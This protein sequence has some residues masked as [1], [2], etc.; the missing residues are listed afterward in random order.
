VDI[1]P[2]IATYHALVKLLDSGYKFSVIT[3]EHA[4][5]QDKDDSRGKSREFLFKM[6]YDL[7]V[8]NVR[9]LPDQYEFEDWWVHPDLVDMTHVEQ[10]RSTSEYIFWKKYLYGLT[11]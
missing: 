2:S 11:K 8:P 7:L 4:N 10:F 1:E 9:I 3:F 6:G 5:Y